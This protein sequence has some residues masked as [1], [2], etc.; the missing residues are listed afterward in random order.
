MTRREQRVHRA[1]TSQ[2]NVL[3]DSV[4]RKLTEAQHL[5]EL[6]S[7]EKARLEQRVA[8]LES[9]VPA[10]G[11]VHLQHIHHSDFLPRPPQ[12]DEEM[13]GSGPVGSAGLKTAPKRSGRP[14]VGRAQTEL[15]Y[16]T[17]DDPLNLMPRGTS[18]LPRTETYGRT[19]RSPQRRKSQVPMSRI[20]P[21]LPREPLSD[22]TA[23]VQC[24]AR[25]LSK[26]DLGKITTGIENVRPSS[27]TGCVD[28]N[29]LMPPRTPTR[30]LCS[31]TV[32]S[33]R[34]LA[35]PSP[36][37]STARTL[38]TDNATDLRREN[39]RP[40]PAPPM[41]AN[42]LIE[43]MHKARFTRDSKQSTPIYN[44]DELPSPFIKKSYSLRP[45]DLGQ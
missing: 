33:P 38:F 21:E 22:Q 7:E 13:Y 26:Q 20:R 39:Q 19:L 36:T 37:R 18:Q 41:R 10:E 16:K 5:M 45:I 6:L 44:E 3:Q 11:R 28:K 9:C 40:A 1:E 29:A 17:N 4:Q 8:Q 31:R 2:E 35:F 23:G 25:A 43:G 32:N 12:A 15:T 27:A 24:L 30:E 42:T 14:S 34:R